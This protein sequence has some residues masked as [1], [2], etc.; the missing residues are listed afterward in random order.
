MTGKIVAGMA[1][2]RWSEDWMEYLFNTVSEMR[3]E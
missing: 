2:K 1:D 3:M